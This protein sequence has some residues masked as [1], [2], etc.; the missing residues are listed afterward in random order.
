MTAFAGSNKFVYM[1]AR[2]VSTNQNSGNGFDLFRLS[3]SKEFVDV[4]PNTL[5]SYFRL[6]L[7]CYRRGKAVFV[8]KTELTEFITKGRA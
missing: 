2:N 7:P 3:K 6:G 4:C 8:S 1:N 5:R